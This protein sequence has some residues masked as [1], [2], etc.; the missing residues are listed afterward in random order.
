VVFKR[1]PMEYET[2]IA[3]ANTLFKS[4]LTDEDVFDLIPVKPISES[5]KEIESIYDQK[6]KGLYSKLTS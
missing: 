6:L 3:A 1:H 2:M 4:G 5:E